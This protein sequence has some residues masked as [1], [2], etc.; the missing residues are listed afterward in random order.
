MKAKIETYIS[1]IAKGTK[2]NKPFFV[3]VGD[4]YFDG[5]EDKEEISGDT[6][7]E[8][9]YQ[10][11]EDCKEQISFVEEILQGKMGEI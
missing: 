4:G 2:N 11:I 7:I 9:L 8:C 5:K 1:G 10:Y 6:T 3:F